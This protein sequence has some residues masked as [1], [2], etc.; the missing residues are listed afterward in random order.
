MMMEENIL[1]IALVLAAV[2]VALILAMIKTGSKKI[3]I[4]VI[5]FT[6]ATTIS[7]FPLFV[8]SDSVSALIITLLWLIIAVSSVVIRRAK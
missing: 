6:T 4:L 2:S 5:M 8:F 7:C 3:A 1:F